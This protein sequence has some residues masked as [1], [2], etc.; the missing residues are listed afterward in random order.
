MIEKDY[1]RLYTGDTRLR[2]KKGEMTIY[3]SNDEVLGDKALYQT[4]NVLMY[5]G[6]ANELARAREGIKFN[7]RLIRRPEMIVEIMKKMY[8]AVLDEGKNLN[9]II[10][11]RLER[12]VA[13][14]ELEKG[15][16]KS[17]FS[18][19]KGGYNNI[20]SHKE[21]LVKIQVKIQP[22][23]FCA[24]L[25]KMLDNEY[26]MDE[27]EVLIPPFTPIHIE[28]AKQEVKC[29]G[30]ENTYTAIIKPQ[31]FTGCVD[32]ER[33]ATLERVVYGDLS[34]RAEDTLKEINDGVMKQGRERWYVLW[35]DALQELLKIDFF[36]LLENRVKESN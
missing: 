3:E 15:Y 5:E 7:L 31:D 33:K 36:E 29:S 34:K 12:L 4:L 17:F 19:S 18:T 2:N 8:S 35:K 20:F 10:T 30:E 25:D 14:R 13:V 16:T 21:G 32:K 22:G 26:I 27:E 1:I 23:V 11:Y 24:D 9:E 6:I 28:K